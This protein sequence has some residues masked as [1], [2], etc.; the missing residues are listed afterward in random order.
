MDPRLRADE[1]LARARA[2]GAFVVTPDNATSPMDASTTVRIPRTVVEQSDSDS[3]QV[4][5]QSQQSQ[6]G[7]QQSHS[8]PQHG[9][10]HHNQQ[11]GH[12][13]HPQPQQG[14][15]HPQQ[16]H[17]HSQGG[18]HGRSQ[19][20]GHGHPQGHGQG[21]QVH[22]QGQQGQ[23]QQATAW[24]SEDPQDVPLNPYQAQRGPGEFGPLG[25]RAAQQHYGQY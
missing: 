18:G 17:G 9:G 14:H 22:G 25:S 1:A 6:S 8:G 11:S 21:Q 23:T 19:G 2:R 4:F 16:G 13:H 3:T 20:Q 10:P 12:Q 24:P 7:S 15:S 5:P